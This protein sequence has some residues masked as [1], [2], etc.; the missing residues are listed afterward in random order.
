M[1]KQI[2]PMLL[3][4]LTAGAGL[5]ADPAGDLLKAKPEAVEAWKDM[6]FD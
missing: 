3:S 2:R 4:L 1:M 5:A 6:R